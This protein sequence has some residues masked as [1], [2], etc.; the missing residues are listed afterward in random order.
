MTA[1]PNAAPR[2]DAAGP[3]GPPHRWGRSQAHLSSPEDAPEQPSTPCCVVEEKS[4]WTVGD[5]DLLVVGPA[6]GVAVVPAILAEADVCA[7][8]SLGHGRAGLRAG[9]RAT[10]HLDPPSDLVPRRPSPGAAPVFGTLPVERFVDHP[11]R[12][13]PDRGRADRDRTRG[14]AR[15]R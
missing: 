12:G 11:P 15:H 2:P 14:S 10:L 9:A 5:S 7:V 8:A 3:T 13:D 4:R 6:L 1:A